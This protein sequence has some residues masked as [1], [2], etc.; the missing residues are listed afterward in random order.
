MAWLDAAS[1]GTECTRYRPGDY[2]IPAA[3]RVDQRAQGRPEPGV[4]LGGR[5]AAAAG[6]P[7]PPGGFGAALE[8]PHP[9]GHRVRV[10][11]GRQSNR[12]DEPP[13]GSD[14]SKQQG[15]AG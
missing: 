6:R 14:R 15:Q 4:V 8:F 11:P 13:G 3:L 2:G 12:L 9:R 10:P 7:H 1:S 5:L